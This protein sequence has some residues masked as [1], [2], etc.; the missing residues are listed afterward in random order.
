[1]GMES[2]LYRKYRPRTFGDMVGQRKVTRPLR[3]AFLEGTLPHSF[4]FA[5]SKGSGKTTAAKILAKVLNC[6]APTAEG[7]PC[8]RCVNC[9]AAD[10]GT[11]PDIVEMDAAS[12][13]G[14]DNVRQLISEVS[15]SPTLGKVR[16]TIV[17]E[18]HMLTTEAFNAL[19]KTMEEPPEGVVFVL[20]TTDFG[21]IPET[22]ASR[23]AVYRFTPISANDVAAT[24]LRVAADESKAG[25]GGH[26][27]ALTEA[28]AAA[29]AAETAG[30]LRDALGSLQQIRDYAG[31]EEVTPEVVYDFLGVTNASTLARLVDLIVAKDL[32]GILGFVGE[33]IDG[34]ME[35]RQLVA[36]LEKYIRKAFLLSVS[37]DNR[38]AF[39]ASADETRTLTAHA[40][41]LGTARCLELM[42][43]AGRTLWRLG[44]NAVPRL[45]LEAG[46]TYMAFPEYD[47]GDV[48]MNARLVAAERRLAAKVDAVGKIIAAVQP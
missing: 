1:M 8:N 36:D 42:E 22:V 34:G 14:I 3:F 23:C 10:A 30:S 33:A 2:T 20:V 47:S 21:K 48:G 28:G 37:P 15:F 7:E 38:K 40:E 17:D 35:P 13:R 12:N 46:L 4:L 24:L 5:G 43:V 16:V 25:G 45:V 27:I 9:R 32:P 31:G 41:I 11:H 19:L 29:I 18:A 44:T 39:Y 6:E 26:P